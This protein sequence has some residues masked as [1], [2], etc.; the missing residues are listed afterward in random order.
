[1]TDYNIK[2]TFS[3]VNLVDGV[4]LPDNYVLISLDAVSLF[5]KIPLELIVNII[6]EKWHLIQPH[7]SLSE[8]NFLKLITFIF[9]KSYFCFNNTYYLLTYLFT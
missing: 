8:T 4:I 7:T 5:T 1:M 9:N 3:F 6:K 2:D